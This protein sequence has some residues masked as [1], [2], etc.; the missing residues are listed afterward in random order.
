M[1]EQA[2]ALLYW[3]LDCPLLACCLHGESMVKSPDVTLAEC[4]MRALKG[5]FSRFWSVR[6]AHKISPGVLKHWGCLMFFC[7][8]W[9]EYAIGGCIRMSD[10]LS[11]TWPLSCPRSARECLGKCSPLRARTPHVL[12]GDNWPV[13]TESV[14][15]KLSQ[16]YIIS[17]FLITE[18]WNKIQLIK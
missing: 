6:G 5:N 4:L 1:A 14:W 9:E 7:L 17:Y 2:W 3:T 11:P 15:T 18:L 13:D 10:F 8:P 12:N 16:F